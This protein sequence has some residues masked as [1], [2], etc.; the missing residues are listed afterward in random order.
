MFKGSILYAVL[1][2]KFLNNRNYILRF[3]RKNIIFKDDQYFLLS[4]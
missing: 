2:N 3:G 1:G 4:F